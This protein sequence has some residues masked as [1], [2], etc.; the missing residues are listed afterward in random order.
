MNSSN[1]GGIH[2]AVSSAK[3]DIVDAKSLIGWM[4]EGWH[5]A[6]LSCIRF[7]LLSQRAL[8]VSLF[9]C[10]CAHACL[11]GKVNGSRVHIAQ[12]ELAECVRCKRGAWLERQ[13][14]P[15]GV[16]VWRVDTGVCR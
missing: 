16:F 13:V 15:L 5:V 9:V 11:A 6:T 14:W 12:F 3:A 1:E 7:F 4:S 10:V 2:V 8:S